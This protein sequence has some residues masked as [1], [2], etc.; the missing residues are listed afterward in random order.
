MEERYRIKVSTMALVEHDGKMLAVREQIPH[1]DPNAPIVLN[2]P[3]G[4]MDPGETVF[5]S[6][7]RECLE[8]TGYTVKPVAVLSVYQ[9]IDSEYKKRRK[10][11]QDKH[12][13]LRSKGTTGDLLSELI[14]ENK[15]IK[16]EEIELKNNLDKKF[17]I[18]IDFALIGSLI[19]I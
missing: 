4:H 9:N 18:V 3:G 13:D 7:V 16:Y 11:I 5:E 15:K 8:E 6:V 2:Q 14:D 12:T 17:S 1:N 19:L 10:D